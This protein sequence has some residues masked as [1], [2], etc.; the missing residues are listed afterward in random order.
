MTSGDNENPTVKTVLRK[1]LPLWI[2]VVLNILPIIFIVG[3]ANDRSSSA[4]LSY[5]LA[6]VAYTLL[7]VFDLIY[8]SIWGIRRAIKA[9]RK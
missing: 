4:Y 6:I 3:L 1:L 7:G 9:M 2:L 5:S 8:L